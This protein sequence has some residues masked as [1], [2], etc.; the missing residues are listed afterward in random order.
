M[1]NKIKFKKESVIS[2]IISIL[3]F[4]L[5]N[6]LFYKKMP[7]TLPTHWGFN[8]KIDGYSSKFTTLITT[9][10]LLI[11]LNIFSCFMLDN[12]PKNKD[13]NNFV[14][15]IGKATIPL[16]MLI[17]FV[18]SVFYGLGKKINVMV[19]ISIF[20][21]F[22][23]ILIGNYLPKTKRNYT[24]GIKLPWTLNSDENWNKTHRLAGYFFILGGIFFL[25][26]PFIGNEYLIFLTFM[27]IGIIPAIYS[28]YLY[29]N[30]V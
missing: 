10:L 6:L 23:L 14:I 11:F 8:N 16:V 25:L 3:L 4:A 24:V 13:K 18:I 20:V 22:L 12:D 5:V 21:G 9:P 7:E 17:T 1:K 26:T 27:I 15:T 2:V 19:I 30:G 28:F 29:K